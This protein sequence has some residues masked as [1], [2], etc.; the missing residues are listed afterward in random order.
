MS[1]SVANA[2]GALATHRLNDL[3]QYS[4]EY[5]IGINSAGSAFEEYVEDLLT[6]R[7]YA[8]PKEREAA[9]SMEFLCLGNQ[10]FPP[11]AIAAGG[12]A[13][14]IKKHE[15]A[16]SAIAL[17]SSRPRDV[18]FP[19]DPRGKLFYAYARILEA[20]MPLLFVAEDVSGIVS[21]KNIAAFRRILSVLSRP[22][23]DVQW[24]LLDS[25]DYCVAQERKRIIIVGMRRDSGIHY[26]FPEK[27]C[28]KEWASIDGSPASRWLTLKDAIGDL[29]E[30]VPAMPGNKLNISLAIPNHEYMV[31]AFSPIYM[32]RNRKRKWGEPS[33]TIQAVGR[34]APLHP[35]SC[36][37]CKVGED[38]F[39]FTGPN[40]RR[41][42]VMEAAR[43]QGFPD[44]FIFKYR[45]IADGYKVIGNAVPSP[46]ARAIAENI[47]DALGDADM[48]EWNGDAVSGQVGIDADCQR[49]TGGL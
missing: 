30:A 23:Y 10:N 46:L 9:F 21:S 33:Y 38:R 42:S 41:L 8:S 48:K 6:G 43:V 31:G 32:S 14:E 35:D 39:E 29:P 47:I 40:Y 16:A 26:R 17:N 34:H 13:F 5:K 12:D 20:K 37:M 24:K 25:R 11:D 45:N 19:D 2:M 3:G 49:E 28:T 22:G 27:R 36:D 4:M 18:L 1:A 7:F 15:R 44:S